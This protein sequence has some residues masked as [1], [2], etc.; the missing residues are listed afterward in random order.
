MKPALL[1][2]LAALLL[3][4]CSN[5]QMYDTARNWQRNQCLRAQDSEA[6]SQCEAR[7]KT[8]YDNYSDA[9]ANATAR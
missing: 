1:L 6:R 4:A 7:A 3:G 8:S 5:Q 2:P 9:R